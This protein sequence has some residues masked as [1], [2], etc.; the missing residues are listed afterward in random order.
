MGYNALIVLLGTG[1]LGACAGMVG[2]FAVLRQRALVGDALA[3]AALPGV[4][5]AFLIVGERNLPAMLLGAFFA[6]ILGISIIT[7]LRRGTRLKD[8]AAIGIVLS[9]FYGGGIALSR[10]IQNQT[11]GGSRAGLESYILGK[12]S[13]MI[14]SDVYWIA[15]AAIFSLVFVLLFYKEFKVVAFD[16]G[17]AAGQGWPA[18][19]LDLMLMALVAVTVVIGLPAVGVILVAA[20]LIIP[21]SAARFWTDRLGVMLVLAAVIGAGSASVGTWVS[22]QFGWAAGPSIVLAGTG[23]FLVSMMF[24]PQKG[25]VWRGISGWGAHRRVSRET[26]LR[27]VYDL[28]EQNEFRSKRISREA[29]QSD[30][31]F[32]N[33][34]SKGA[35]ER[36]ESEGVVMSEDPNAGDILVTE[37]GWKAVVEAEREHRLWGLALQEMNGSPASLFEVGNTAWSDLPVGITANFE[38][39]LKES[40]RDPRE[41]RLRNDVSEAVN[42]SGSSSREGADR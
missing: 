17:F 42:A 2:T 23:L 25:V 13:G 21:A 38:S 11:T 4:C 16:P 10:F 31:Y 19:F 40:G 37:S 30:V 1:I 36:L 34:E 27:H 6:G 8:D 3:H 20:L 15:G 9:V 29:I 41:Q 24:S 7:G 35:L 33:Q 22:S 26:L 32:S 39:I 18:F 28:L 14:T 5:V 12:T